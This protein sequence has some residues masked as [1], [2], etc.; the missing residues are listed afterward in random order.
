MTVFK[1]NSRLSKIEHFVRVSPPSTSE[2]DMT[3]NLTEAEFIVLSHVA[4]QDSADSSSV[5]VS[6]QIPHQSVDSIV[7]ALQSRGYLNGFAVTPVGVA[8]LEPYKVRNAVV[9]AAGMSTR[10]API[11]YEKPKGLL[12]VGGEVLIERTIRQLQEVGITEIT[13]VLGYMMEQFLYLEDM[14]GVK[15]RINPEYSSR[16]TNSTLKL[17]ED[18]LDNTYICYA[19]NYYARNIFEPYAYHAYYSSAYHE[20]PT[21][22]WAL[23]VDER[24]RI[25]QVTPGLGDSWVMWGPVYFDRQFSRDFVPILNRVYDD[26]ETPPKLWEAIYADHV[27]EVDMRIRRYEAGVIFEFDSLEELKAFDENFMVNVDSSILDNIC[28]TLNVARSDLGEFSPMTDGLSNLSF[29]FTAQGK[30]Y[31]YRHPGAFTVGINDRVAEAQAE[32]VAQDLGLDKSYI[33]LNPEK[34]W[35]IS[36]FIDVSEPFDYH[37]PIH[38]ARSLDSIRR[39]HHSG[40]NIEASFD[41]YD[42]GLKI[43]DRL[44][45]IGVGGATPRF[46][47]PDFYLLKDRAAR[48]K[49][50]TDSDQ[51]G[52]VLCHNDFYEPNILIT[53]KDIYLIDWEFSGMN[54]YASDLGTLICC[55]DYTYEEALD[56]LAVYFGRTPTDAEIKHC[57]AHISLSGY[58]WWIWALNKDVCGEPVGEWTHLWYRF[59]K[60][61]GRKAIELYERG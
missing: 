35:K 51:V 5:F 24:D 7:E 12:T 27:T 21:Q 8:V 42:E 2:E 20:G 44:M 6:P 31:V 43:T 22:E 30:K 3:T 28:T 59:A 46:D 45:S 1:K 36:H 53:D 34:G 10:F 56:V 41:L 50:L 54:D 32:K 39:L 37:N 9:M 13:V 18:L 29:S 26:P 48:L 11:S 49:E 57:V 23:T 4:T 52:K 15:I 38:V 61:Y 47:F 17:V 58:Y 19:D 33:Y 16:N 14:F 60:E 55:S 25:T 40:R